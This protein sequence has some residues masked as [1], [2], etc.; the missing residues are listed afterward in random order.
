MLCATKRICRTCNDDESI[1]KP[2]YAALPS[3]RRRLQSLESRS[4]FVELKYKNYSPLL[5]SFAHYCLGNHGTGSGRLVLPVSRKLTGGTVVTSKAVD[6]GFD[7]NQSELGVLVLSVALQVLSDLDSLLDKHVKVLWDF[8]GKT[9]S[10]KDA[11]NLLSS[12]GLDLSDT[13]GVTK[14]DTNLGGGQTLLGKLADV[15]LNIGGRDLQPRRRRALVWE[16]SLGDTLSWCMH[17][18][19]AVVFNE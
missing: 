8:R 17:T 19:H 16:G 1:A 6:S 14:N 12:D 9:V 11:N 5:F 7:Q 2:R 15:F 3:A 4:T 10:L 13:V 18:T